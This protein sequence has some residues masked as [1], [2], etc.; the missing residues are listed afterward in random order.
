[1]TE[2]ISSRVVNEAIMENFFTQPCGISS[3]VAGQK[4]LNLLEDFKIF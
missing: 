2:I 4:A 1:M 3:S